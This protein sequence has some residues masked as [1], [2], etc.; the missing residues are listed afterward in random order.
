L[1]WTVAE[2]KRAVAILLGCARRPQKLVEA[3]SVDG[4]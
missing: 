2:R 1:R 3:W 4:S